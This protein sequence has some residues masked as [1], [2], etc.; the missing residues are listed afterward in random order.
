MWSDIYRDLRYAARMLLRTPGF[1]AVVVITLALGIG[2]NSA[3]FSAIDAILLRAAPVADPSR[4]VSVYT[5]GS[6]ARNQ[7][8]SSSYLD[9][10]D[11]RD[12]RAFAGL[13][14][15]ASIVLAFEDGGVVKQVTGEVVSGNYFDVLGVRIA[16]GRG[17]VAD[18]DRAGSPVRVAVASHS[19]WRRR[20][21]ATPAAI[22]RTITLNGNPF[23]VIGVTPAGFT[24]PT[25]GVAPDIWVPMA[26]QPE[27][28]PPSAGLRRSLGGFGLLE[29]RG[30][31]WLNMVGRLKTGATVR[32]AATSVD[33]VASRLQASFPDSNR[34]RRF[35]VVLLGDGP[36]VRA[37]ARP[38]LTVLGISVVLVLLIACAN[39]ASLLAARA[40][41]RTREVAVRMAVGADRGRL[42]RQWLTES[43]L[44]ALIG[45]AGALLV[46]WWGTPLLYGF[47]VPESVRLGLN[48]RVFLFTLVAGVASGVLFGLAPVVQVL[49]G[50]TLA[51]LRDEG[52]TI[53]S[54]V[55]AARMRSV[56]VVAQV[57]LSLMLLVGAGLFLR[58][59]QNA[60]AVDLGY[61]TE[62]TLVADINLDVR[63]YTQQA[64]QDVY[65]RLLDR[66]NALPGVRAA[67]ASRVPVLSGGSRTGTISVDGRP[68]AADGSNGLTVRINVVSDRYLDALGIP[69]ALG[70]G[71]SPSDAG[72]A[73]RVVIVSRQF[74]DRL[75]PGQDPL[76]RTFGSA[77]PLTVIGVVPDAAYASA[78]ER[79][80]PPVFYLPLAQNYE[81]GVT[82]YV[83]TA[84][85]PMSV[86]PAVRQIV[87]E[88]DSRLR[89]RGSADARGRIRA[90]AR[91][92]APHGHA[93]RIVRWP[94]APTGRDR[95][96]R[97]DGP[98][99]RAAD[100]GNRH[101]SRPWRET[102]VHLDDDRPS[103]IAAGRDRRRDRSG[104]RD[105]LRP[106]RREPALRR[107]ADRSHDVRH[108]RGAARDRECPRMRRSGETSHED[109]PGAHA[110][111]LIIV[112]C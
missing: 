53:A 19:F 71:F 90:L 47:G 104:R 48:V 93:R 22:G 80:P 3:I 41:S 81:S 100:R 40:V 37:V 60:Y 44:L 91:Q 18:E 112:D 6:D 35:T 46:A 78:I 33:L 54:G 58:T 7:F 87:R 83:R 39:I 63:G 77:A 49:R 34:D 42:I 56:F 99:G 38:F 66:V 89:R 88:I 94:C 30:L 13:A 103:G 26:L 98:H 5:S 43:M 79:N 11:L 106:R 64:G 8:S 82:L 20:L 97:R 111:R 107:E 96:V 109:R 24:A 31:R 62:G 105:D 65:A 74:A 101:P 85:D 9:H 68:V 70:R 76:G 16:P 75:W 92:P 50:D 72:T 95:T 108:C 52:G 102:L 57:A 61:R 51:A 4:V 25:L 2:A 10:L 21:N 86:L 45:S 12:S 27:V 32:D 1:T 110:P 73:P 59:L 55:R 17:F 69:I 23:T 29:A 15:F 28:R 84:S 14:A 67:G 36:G